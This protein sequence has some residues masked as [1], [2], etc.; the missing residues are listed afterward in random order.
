MG[1]RKNKV[2]KERILK[3]KSE[4]TRGQGRVE[5]SNS[6]WNIHWEGGWGGLGRYVCTGLYVFEIRDQE[7][8]SLNVKERDN[9]G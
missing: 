5:D 6:S 1:T 4:E 2:A 3:Q 9:I 8:E 7:I